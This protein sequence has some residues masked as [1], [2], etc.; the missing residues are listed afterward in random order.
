MTDGTTFDRLKKLIVEQLA[1]K[2]AVIVLASLPPDHVPDVEMA[3]ARRR[4]GI[5]RQD[6]FQ[7]FG[8]RSRPMTRPVF[9]GES[10]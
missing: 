4:V 3:G 7:K 5:V 9:F 2:F 1:M 6:L 8:Q 10:D